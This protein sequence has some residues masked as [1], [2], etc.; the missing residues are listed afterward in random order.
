MPLPWVVA[1][2][3]A[4]L[5]GR[6]ATRGDDRP[7]DRRFV[8]LIAVYAI[9]SVIIGLRWGYGI[10]AI[11]PLQSVLA[12][13]LPPLAWL[14][15]AGL[16][17]AGRQRRW[18]HALPACLVLVLIVLW[19]GPID[20]VI[21]AT[22]LAYG[23][24]LV[25][26]ALAGPD[27]LRL[28]PLDEAPLVHRAVQVTAAALLAS[29]FLDL[30]IWLDLQWWGGGHAALLVGLANVP[31]LLLLGI[32]AAVAGRRQAPAEE[33]APPAMPPADS[34]D[35]EIVRQIDTLMR[36]RR[37]FREP[38][39]NLDR[40][41]RKAGIPARRISAAVNRLRNRNVS[42]YVNDHRIAEACRL[43][44]DT[45]LPV[46]AIML[47]V[48]FQTKSNFNREF[49]RVTGTS[50]MAWRADKGGPTQAEASASAGPG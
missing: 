9:L 30:A 20:V 4:I 41:A 19:P 44:A 23:S 42:Q 17:A 31:V 46:T 25:R 50:P 39:L 35:V 43:L 48:G 38:D 10:E 18:P 22:F 21:I 40:L 24:A 13:L 27:A 15:F 1:L 47:E 32:A 2:L 34:K 7:A 49:R 16:T 14:C 37:V 33:P 12:A 28:A 8:A 5:L 6:M 45:D 11:L 26:L 29:A 36:T 3:L